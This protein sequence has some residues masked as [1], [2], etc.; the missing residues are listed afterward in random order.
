MYIVNMYHSYAAPNPLAGH[1]D[2]NIINS[3]EGNARRFAPILLVAGVGL[4]IIHGLLYPGRSFSI[5]DPITLASVGMSIAGGYFIF[6]N[7]ASPS[8]YASITRGYY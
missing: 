6:F 8:H 3:L 7:A 4:F 2:Q 1:S 5:T